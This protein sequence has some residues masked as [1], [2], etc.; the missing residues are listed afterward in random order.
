MIPCSRPKFS[1]LYTVCV[2][3]MLENHTLHSGTYLYSPY[4]A[5]PPPPRGGSGWAFKLQ[6]TVVQSLCRIWLF[7][8]PDFYQF[9]GNNIGSCRRTIWNVHWFHQD[10]CLLLAADIL[11]SLLRVSKILIKLICVGKQPLCNS[12]FSLRKK[13]K[14]SSAQFLHYFIFCFA[15]V[16]FHWTKP[17]SPAPPPAQT[18]NKNG[19]VAHKNWLA[20]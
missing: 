19:D 3:K 12:K 9:P 6:L 5:D 8:S 18:V 17:N 13:S 1:D 16:S 7:S 11:D 4:M 2:S 20:L 10:I 14:V 15:Y